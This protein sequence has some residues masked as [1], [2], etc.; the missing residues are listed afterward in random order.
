[1]FISLARN[2]TNGEEAGMDENKGM[3]SMRHGKDNEQVKG[4]VSKYI[5]SSLGRATT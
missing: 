2:E 3:A 1:M 4:K 5:H